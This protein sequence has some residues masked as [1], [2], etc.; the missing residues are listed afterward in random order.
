MDGEGQVQKWNVLQSLKREGR[1]RGSETEPINW[2]SRK[3][4]CETRL[5][6]KKKGVS[7]QKERT[8]ARQKKDKG[9]KLNLF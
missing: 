1:S 3:I 2:W 5:V 9:K 8:E 4:G 7:K 6:S